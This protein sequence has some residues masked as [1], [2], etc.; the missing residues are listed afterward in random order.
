MTDPVNTATD[1]VI[2]FRSDLANKSTQD[3]FPEEPRSFRKLIVSPNDLSNTNDKEISVPSYELL[4]TSSGGNGRLVIN[5]LIYDGL[6][7]ET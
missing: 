2:K 1:T 3:T 4:G 6:Y 5:D 7:D